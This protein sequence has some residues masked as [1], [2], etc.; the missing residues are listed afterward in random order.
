M[1][2]LPKEYYTIVVMHLLM[3]N[4][5]AVKAVIKIGKKMELHQVLQ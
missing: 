3:E 2:N 1:E 4:S 5:M